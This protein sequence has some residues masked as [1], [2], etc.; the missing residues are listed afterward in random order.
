MTTHPK[1][2]HSFNV[3]TVNKCRKIPYIKEEGRDVLELAFGH[4]R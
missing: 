1:N 3:S 4:T 2:Y